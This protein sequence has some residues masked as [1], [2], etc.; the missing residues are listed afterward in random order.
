MNV[1]AVNRSGGTRSWLSYLLVS[2]RQRA[3]IHVVENKCSY[4]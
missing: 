2:S 4:C 1:V 3:D